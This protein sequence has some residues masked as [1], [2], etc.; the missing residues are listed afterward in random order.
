VAR[1]WSDMRPPAPVRTVQVE[2]PIE[3]VIARLSGTHDGRRL[4]E[5]LMEEALR[6][7]PVGAPDS[8]VREADGARRLVDRL[9][10]M[11]S[12]KA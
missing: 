10:D 5:F 2:D 12:V 3:T 4:F 7:T 9:R 6:P 8:L 11:A 1:K